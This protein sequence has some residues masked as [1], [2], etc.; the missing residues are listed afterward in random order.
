MKWI[1][2]KFCRL[3]WTKKIFFYFAEV[4]DV[5]NS[6]L[7]LLSDKSAISNGTHQILDGGMNVAWS[8]IKI[9]E[10]I[11]QSVIIGAGHSMGS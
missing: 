5:V 7:F 2:T 3:A 9:M 6:V 1:W 8:K 4:E 11:L 10:S